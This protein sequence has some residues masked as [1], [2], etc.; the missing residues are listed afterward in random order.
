M[1]FNRF[2]RSK[3]D[4]DFEAVLIRTSKQLSM[5][6]STDGVLAQLMDLQ[7]SL[8]VGQS[9]VILRA[10]L[11]YDCY[12]LALNENLQALREPH[13]T[14][15]FIRRFVNSDPLISEFQALN[16]S[17]SFFSDLPKSIHA[18]LRDL[19]IH[20]QS[21]CLVVTPLNHVE[22]IFL[23]GPKLSAERYNIRDL[24]LFEVVVNQAVLVF[25]RIEKMQQL[26]QSNAHTEA[27][28]HELAELNQRLEEQV[29]EEV[30]ARNQAVSA[31]QALAN[32]ATMATLT[33]G[34]SHEIRNPLTSI[35]AN[36]ENLHSRLSGK[37]GEDPHPWT[38]KLTTEILCSLEGLSPATADELL[39]HLKT[40]G[41]LSE[42]GEVTPKCNPFYE[43]LRVVL[44]APLVL[45][46]TS[47]SQLIAE[48]FKQKQ[49]LDYLELI[50]RESI[51]VV[52]ITNA[53]LQY[54]S[55]KGVGQEAFAK[56][57]GFNAEKSAKLWQEL[58]KKK[59]LDA[60]GG[61]L[62]RFSP[63]TPGFKLELSE[64]FKASHDA[65]VDILAALPGA[66]KTKLDPGIPIGHVLQLKQSD[67]SKH[68]IQASYE[69]T[70]TRPILGD[71]N[72]LFQILNILVSNAVE[73]ME[74]EP[75]E[76]K[77]LLALSVR[78]GD[79]EGVVISVSDT[80]CGMSE[81]I[82]EKVK[83]P[84]F[85]TK[86]VTGGKNAGL[87]MSILFDIMEN[88]GGKVTIHSIPRGGTTIDLW[89]PGV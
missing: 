22:V 26:A 62:S 12:Q 35:K 48:T 80:G 45:Y 34:I 9:Y 46:S 49:V 25:E 24:A 59:Y 77:R 43:V 41:Y 23:V 67:F 5:V 36:V 32:K 17:V 65:I 10:S 27:L 69:A 85:T 1:F 11:G 75:T 84:F 33:A 51:R 71:Q 56:L 55:V 76:K 28:N 74:S 52:S 70:H 68:N 16:K 30:N 82:I 54:G 19:T 58:V 73:A 39:T 20:D 53:M 79:E 4:Y 78:D 61:I 60:Y 72:R 13:G 21:V 7:N 87:G 64:K 18:Q 3:L 14:R 57:T 8:K 89:I 86:V 50:N 47:V 2:F 44:P 6:N 31:A 15:R 38:G 81:E 63:Q 37:T 40:M 88:H 66:K 42:T 29:V 83:D